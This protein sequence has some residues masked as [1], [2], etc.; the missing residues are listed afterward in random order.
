MDFKDEMLK[1]LRLSF[2]ILLA[3]VL[4]GWL[5]GSTIINEFIG[6]VAGVMLILAFAV[7]MFRVW[8]SGELGLDKNQ[9][10]HERSDFNKFIIVVMVSLLVLSYADKWMGKPSEVPA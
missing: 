5:A 6:L 1:T 3:C 8:K 2:W 7:I 4:F 10:Y 9:K